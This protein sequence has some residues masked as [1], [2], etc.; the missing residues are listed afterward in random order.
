M[1][2]DG[3]EAG[4]QKF[5]HVDF[6][7]P[8]PIKPNQLN[9]LKR[10]NFA[11]PER[12]TIVDPRHPL[13]GQTFPLLHLKNKQNLVPCGLVR[14]ATGAERLIPLSVT[15][16]APIPPNVFSLPLDLSSLH[17]LTQTFSRILAQ[18][19]REC[20]DET[21]AD[22]PTQALGHLASASLGDAEPQ[23]TENSVANP[24]PDVLPAHQSTRSGEER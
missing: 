18:V 22:Q 24:C 10:K 14:L 6:P 15:D 17:N 4:T 12:I 23:S 7:L 8:K 2:L 11:V 20:G 16:L 21:A 1:E 19:E 9:T 3:R 5:Y 13:F